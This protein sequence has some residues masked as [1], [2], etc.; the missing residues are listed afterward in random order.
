MRTNNLA[1]KGN[2]NEL[3]ILTARPASI[4][5]L[6]PNDLHGPYERWNYEQSFE[7]AYASAINGVSAAIRVM[8]LKFIVGALG[9]DQLVMRQ[10]A[11][12]AMGEIISLGDF[13]DEKKTEL[14]TRLERLEKEAAGTA[15]GSVVSYTLS[16]TKSLGKYMSLHKSGT[17]CHL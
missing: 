14:L 12:V 4:V 2:H 17:T 13:P 16:R 8:G 5:A 15:L 6:P 11:V 7:D 3:P 9:H 10:R 1:E